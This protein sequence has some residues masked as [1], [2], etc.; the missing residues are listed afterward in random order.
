MGGRGRER[1]LVTKTP[2]ST[3][4]FH[5]MHAKGSEAKK[6][7]VHILTVASR[8]SKDSRLIF[9]T[10]KVRANTRPE[11]RPANRIG[12]GDAHALG[13]DFRTPGYG[14]TLE[15]VSP[16]KNDGTHINHF[17]KI[18]SSL[19][20]RP[21]NQV[22]QRSKVDTHARESCAS[23]CPALRSFAAWQ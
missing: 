1:E 4:P 9:L 11:G 16:H 17:C 21:Q 13:G 19:W 3:A 10:V 7:I 22:Y 6:E 14:N 2:H 23:A 20:P 5:H 15:P 12:S 8:H 18:H